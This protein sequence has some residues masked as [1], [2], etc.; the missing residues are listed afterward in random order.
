MV[1]LN[2]ATPFFPRD[3]NKNTFLYLFS[4][5]ID[6]CL[7]FSPSLTS[8]SYPVHASQ[9]QTDSE[10]MVVADTTSSVHNIQKCCQKKTHFTIS[11]P[12]TNSPETIRRFG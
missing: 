7:G 8:P 1:C 3:S 2:A 11:D 4:F 9:N 5:H 12:D 10:L 6:S